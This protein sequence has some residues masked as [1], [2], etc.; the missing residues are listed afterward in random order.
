MKTVMILLCAGGVLAGGGILTYAMAVKG[1]ATPVVAPPAAIL[2]ENTS[3]G[4]RLTR[5]N[6]SSESRADQSCE[7]VVIRGQVLD[8]DGKPLPAAKLVFLGEQEM[9]ENIG[10]SGSDGAFSVTVPKLGSPHYLLALKDGAGLDFV[11]LSQDKIADPI[12]L[13]LVKDNV[14]HG[15]VVDTEGKPIAG[16]RVSVQRVIDYGSSADSLLAEWKTRNEMAGLPASRKKLWLDDGFAVPAQ[17]SGTDGSFVISAVGR[18]RL[19]GLRLRGAGIGDA[20]AWVVNR[21]GFD[22]KPY[23]EAT[24]HNASKYFVERGYEIRWLLRA[25][26]FSLIAEA[27]KL[28]HGVVVDA[29]TGKPRPG[30]EVALTRSGDGLVR[31]IPK[32]KT[33]ANGRY[34]LHGARKL[35]SYMVEVKPDAEAGYMGSQARANDTPGYEPLT[36][37]IR[38]MR[39]VVITGRV[40]DQS[41]G[42]AVPGLAYV[43]VLSDNPFAKK[44]PEFNSAASFGHEATRDDG[45]FR[46]VTIPGPVLSGWQLRQPSADLSKS[47]RSFGRHE[48]WGFLISIRCV[49]MGQQ[50]GRV[51]HVYRLHQHAF[52]SIRQICL[53]L[54]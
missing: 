15:R 48:R 46:I 7:K 18:E 24:R 26:E 6:D 23:N 43:G 41:T 5:S 42:E 32:A 37:D 36:I 45:T 8:P 22:P 38:V 31:V 29:D 10:A 30:V 3:R 49:T 52:L 53:A 50:T 9:P 47:F 35:K 28:I 33:D 51:F 44:Y 12:E 1:P 17:T 34:Q 21:P 39:G 20:E 40:V 27:E 16:V 13:R 2:V 11:E 19:A 4:A 14:I 54:T 25:P